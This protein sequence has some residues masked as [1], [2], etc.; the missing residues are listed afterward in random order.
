M[1]ADK[2]EEELVSINLTQPRFPQS[3]FMGRLRHFLDV[4]DVRTLFVTDEQLKKAKKL[5]E[6][7]KKKGQPPIR[8]QEAEQLWK[9]KKSLH[10]FFLLEISLRSMCFL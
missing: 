2:G 9:A 5:I 3:T 4:T 1:K 10:L 6:E 8:R 7:Y